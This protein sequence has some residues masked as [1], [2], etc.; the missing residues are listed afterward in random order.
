MLVIIEGEGGG[1]TKAKDYCFIKC[2][3][4]KI[5]KKSNHKIVGRR[6]YIS[7]TLHLSLK[8]DELKCAVR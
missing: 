8:E 2:R 1:F 5:C 7:G 6:I 3:G 4:W